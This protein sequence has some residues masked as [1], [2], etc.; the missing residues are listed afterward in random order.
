M[1]ARPFRK[2]VWTPVLRGLAV[3]SC[4]AVI[5]SAAFGCMTCMPGRSATGAAPV[6]GEAAITR[7][8]RDLV[9]HLSV[10]IGERNVGHPKE[11]L[12]AS[13]WLRARLQDTGRPVQE[14]V[15]DVRG[16]PCRNLEIEFAGKDRASEIVVI[17]AHYDSP[18]GSSGANDNAS[19]A[20]AVVFLAKRFASQAQPS[21]T[22]R[23]VEFVNEEPP[24]FRTDDM[25][26]RRYAK[27]CR[28]KGENIVAMLSLE[29]IGY[30]SDQ[31]GSQ[32]YP[33]PASLFYPSTGNFIA[34]VGD[35]S[36][37]GLVRR[38]VGSFRQHARFPSEGAAFPSSMEGV[39]WSD[40][41]SFWK[42]GYSAVMVT[43][44]APFRYPWYH[45]RDDTPGKMDFVRYAR[46][47]DGLSALISDLSAAP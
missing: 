13:T 45:R 7:D 34:F 20:A 31:P 32:Q 19:G 26:S 4:F 9:T 25:G 22:I 39:G 41:E 1:G 5:P 23:F 40:H 43:D 14:Q 16:V 8:L 10:T 15:Y 2:G 36:S 28:D 35:T 46:L 11:L 37:R 24:W 27:A 3:A 42:A 6:A 12:E 18:P 38:V 47:V 30:Y 33:F 44:T 17:G 21:R 29:T